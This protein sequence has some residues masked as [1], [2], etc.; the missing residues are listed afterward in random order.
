M[1]SIIIIKYYDF[2]I[3]G[4]QGNWKQVNSYDYFADYWIQKWKQLVAHFC[5]NN[6]TEKADL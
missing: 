4:N 3:W 6:N 2:I 5:L 1:Y